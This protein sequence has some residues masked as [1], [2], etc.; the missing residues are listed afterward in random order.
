MFAPQTLAA[1]APIALRLI[2]HLDADLL[3]S[4]ATLAGGLAGHD[5]G[6]ILV[7][8]RDVQT[9]GEDQMEELADVIRTARAQGRDVRLD[10]R[11]L[12]WRT[13]LK[14]SLRLQPPVTPAMR[15]DVRRTVIIAHSGKSKRR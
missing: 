15:S 2:G 12:P 9:F 7:D 4:F 14:R 11:T 8:V 1:P 5:G 3:A 6:T 13:V 10:A